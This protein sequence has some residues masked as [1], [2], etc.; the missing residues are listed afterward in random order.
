MNWNQNLIKHTPAHPPEAAAE[1]FHE[2]IQSFSSLS[3][4]LFIYS[5][6]I[7][8]YT[9]PRLNEFRP[10]ASLF[11]AHTGASTLQ[12]ERP[13]PPAQAHQIYFEFFN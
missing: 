1:V 10:L 3:V 4:P 6:I 2:F 5:F 8:L 7:P 12:T 13:P 9:H 11:G